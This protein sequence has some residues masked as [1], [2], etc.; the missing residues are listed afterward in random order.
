MFPKDIGLDLG[1]A[2]VLIHI[3]GQGIVL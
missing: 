3:K 1:T 2:N